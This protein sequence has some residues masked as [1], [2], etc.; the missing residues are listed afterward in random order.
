MKSGFRKIR[1]KHIKW[2]GKERFRARLLITQ[3]F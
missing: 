3:L 1:E 2:T